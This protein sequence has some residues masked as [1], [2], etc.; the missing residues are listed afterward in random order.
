MESGSLV[1]ILC[2]LSF[3][4]LQVSDL[5]ILSML[6]FCLDYGKGKLTDS[7]RFSD[8]YAFLGSI[9]SLTHLV[10]QSVTQ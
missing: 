8:A 6:T 4:I 1:A 7:L 3:V 10:T 9:L 2:L 5:N